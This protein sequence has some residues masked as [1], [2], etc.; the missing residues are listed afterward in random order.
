MIVDIIILTLI[1]LFMA[2][3]I[4]GTILLIMDAEDRCERKKRRKK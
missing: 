3:C 2:T 4:T 1:G